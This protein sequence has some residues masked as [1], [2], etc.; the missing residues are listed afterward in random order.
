M[1]RFIV[2]I[3]VLFAFSA[4]ASG[5]LSWQMV[6]FD[7]LL[8]GAVSYHA[9]GDNVVVSGTAFYNAIGSDS[10]LGTQLIGGDGIDLEVAGNFGVYG[11]F[12]YTDNDSVLG[13]A[14][15]N[16]DTLLAIEIRARD[17]QFDTDGDGGMDFVDNYKLDAADVAETWL[18]ATF[19]E[20]GEWGYTEIADG[21]WMDIAV[22]S[23][24]GVAALSIVIE[25]FTLHGGASNLEAALLAGD[26]GGPVPGHYV[27]SGIRIAP[28]PVPGAV[29]L[30]FLGLGTACRF[31]RRKPS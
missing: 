30:G 13:W 28:V 27:G 3:V 25:D 22:D 9:G 10:Y 21:V 17:L 15:T 7:K 12:E 1:R 14:A 2:S 18:T 20:L 31:L 4:V 29:L 6:G 19:A 8:K 11:V 26:L 23:G 5:D 16:A 24:N